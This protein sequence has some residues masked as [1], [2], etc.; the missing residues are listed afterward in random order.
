MLQCN[1]E[2]KDGRDAI[3]SCIADVDRSVGE[4]GVLA[5]ASKAADTALFVRVGGR[6]PAGEP[7]AGE[8]VGNTNDTQR[9]SIIT[10]IAAQKNKGMLTKLFIEMHNRDSTTYDLAVQTVQKTTVATLQELLKALV[11]TV[12]ASRLPFI[13]SQIKMIFKKPPKEK[14]APPGVAAAVPVL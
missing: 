7:A 14:V 3:L 12:D 9:T 4:L 6:R 2:G 1:L 13:E 5:T 8:G 11:E 10:R